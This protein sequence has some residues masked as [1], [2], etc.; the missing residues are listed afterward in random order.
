M[1]DRDCLQKVVQ[2]VACVWFCDWGVHGQLWLYLLGQ[3]SKWQFAVTSN[4]RKTPCLSQVTQSCAF[5]FHVRSTLKFECG[6]VHHGLGS[7][8]IMETDNE[9]IPPAHCA[10]RPFSAPWKE[11]TQVCRQPSF[12]SMWV[13]ELSVMVI[14]ELL[15]NRWSTN[16]F[17]KWHVCT[18]LLDL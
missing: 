4:K 9:L 6:C 13:G 1:A 8:K 15:L 10:T 12:R 16:D 7:D 18:S 17:I 5:G 11:D 14:G 3:L 2:P